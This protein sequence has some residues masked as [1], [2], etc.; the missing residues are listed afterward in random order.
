[1]WFLFTPRVSQTPHHQEMEKHKDLLDLE[2]RGALTHLYEALQHEWHHRSRFG[3]DP[4]TRASQMYYSLFYL[5]ICCWFLCG[6]QTVRKR[7]VTKEDAVKSSSG[8]KREEVMRDGVG[9]RREVMLVRERREERK[10]RGREGGWG[11]PAQR[12]VLRI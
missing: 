10:G 2:K 11:G 9:D 4:M 5:F 12:R 3:C 1:M 8:L 6:F 7:D